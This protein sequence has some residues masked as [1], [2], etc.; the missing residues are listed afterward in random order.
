MGRSLPLTM[1]V[2]TLIP[3]FSGLPMAMT[4]SPTP[5][6]PESPSVS[7][8]STPSDASPFMTATSV[9]GSSPTTSAS[10]RTPLANLTEMSSAPPTT[11]WLVTMWPRSSSTNPEPP[12]GPSSDEATSTLTTPGP[13]CVY[14]SRT[15]TPAA[16]SDPPSTGGKAS[17]KITS[18][19]PSSRPVTPTKIKS[20]VAVTSPPT[21][22]DTSAVNA[23]FRRGS[24]RGLRPSRLRG[25]CAE[26][27]DGPP[28]YTPL[29]ILLHEPPGSLVLLDLVGERGLGTPGDGRRV[30]GDLGGRPLD[31]LH[32][33]HGGERAFEGGPVR[34]SA[35]P[36][37][38]AEKLGGPVVISLGRRR[39]ELFHR[40]LGGPPPREPAPRLGPFRP[41]Y[42]F[43]LVRRSRSRSGRRPRGGLL[44]GT[45]SLLV[46]SSLRLAVVG[47]AL[48]R[49][50]GR[51]S[52]SGLFVP[53]PE[54]R[55]GRE[56]PDHGEHSH[57]GQ[58]DQKTS[59]T[60][61]PHGAHRAAGLARRRTARSR[62]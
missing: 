22:A 18:V 46:L 50:V 59:P 1:P 47:R 44:V 60:V 45:A 26:V 14:T 5:T 39:V 34:E 57:E 8:S 42:L 2:V 52:V 56:R 37:I 35:L 40:P 54:E 43:R 41:L 21:I 29:A 51:G 13:V 53:S 16:P 28:V 32:A 24:F 17:L 4:G 12:P 19:V 33:L 61:P 9:E 36:P 3:T 20:A 31:E 38:L 49:V 10:S 11:C 6:L 58:G 55:G 27:V 23:V 15:G 7:G 62:G 30:A 25:L 48:S